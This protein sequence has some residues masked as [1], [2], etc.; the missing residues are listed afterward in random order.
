GE[1]LV[2]LNDPEATIPTGFPVND[3]EQES[4][5]EID[6]GKTI[7]L[8]PVTDAMISAGIRAMQAGQRDSDLPVV[9]AVQRCNIGSVRARNEDSSYMFTTETGGQEPMMPFGLFIV[10][11]GMGGHYAGHEASKNVSRL[12]ARQIVE[13]IY[14]PMLYP[15]AAT[16]QIPIQE[17][18]L[19]AVQAAN[20]AI[21]SPDPEKDS[22]TTLTTALVFGRRLH[23]AHVGDSRAYMLAEGE[24]KLITTD[25][26][27]VRRLQEA[28]QL[29]EEE[30]A[31]HPHRNMLYRAVGQ[32]GELEIDIFTQPLPKSGKL[33]LCSDGLWGLVPEPMMQEVLESDMSLQE[34]ADE[35]VNLAVQ[36]GGYDNIT[37][38]LVDFAL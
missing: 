34:M 38:I 35:L 6:I 1:V 15:G 3:A 31:S 21:H 17:V 9:R 37:A 12:V 13:N 18:I 24:L 19:G 4:E 11:D 7:P 27:Y 32:G 2:T 26:S 14:L 23:I 36:A 25:H 5:E 30:A 22:G 33:V 16:P 8:R 28:G 20:A 10:A 29:T